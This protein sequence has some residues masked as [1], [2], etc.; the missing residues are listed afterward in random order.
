MTF[1]E[2]AD[3]A[4]IVTAIATAIIAYRVFIWSKST[5][6]ANQSRQTNNEWQSFNQMVLEDNELL[7]LEADLHPYGKLDRSGAKKMYFYFMWVNLADN[8]LRARKLGRIDDDLAEE[9]LRNQALVTYLDRGFIEQHVFSRGY[10]RDV[11]REFRERWQELDTKEHLEFR[12]SPEI[13]EM[14][15]NPLS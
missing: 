6:I 7:Q 14:V 15:K 3:A 11:C 12:S 9:R 1:S 2:I 13:Q 5:E 10:Q 8:T 4:S